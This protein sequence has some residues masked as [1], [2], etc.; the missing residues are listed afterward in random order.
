MNTLKK[1]LSFLWKCWFILITII[2][3]F[4]FTVFLIYPFTFRDKDYKRCYFFMRGW[5]L[6]IFYL[7]GL[8]YVF[9]GQSLD[10]NQQYIIVANHTSFMDI[11]LMFTVIK[12]PMMFVGK[13]ELAKFPIF[14]AVYKRTAILVDRKSKRS[15]A[16]VF[17][18]A[19]EKIE[20]GFSICVFPEGGVPNDISVTL[21]NFKNG[22]FSMSVEH[23]L[24]MAVH[25]ICG[26]KERM[27]YDWFTGLPGKIKVFRNEIIP[28]G[29]YSKETINDYKKH[30]YDSIYN[31]LMK[32][33]E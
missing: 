29:T 27:P 14:G 16:E 21:D 10:K 15:R 8:W 18:K 33:E 3:S 17:K 22:A 20:K 24:P 19:A 4:I 1:G 30:V 6:T 28:A 32:C 25:T 2:F 12:N 7:S 9:R 23:N 13:A 11:M 31:Q 26:M 5:G